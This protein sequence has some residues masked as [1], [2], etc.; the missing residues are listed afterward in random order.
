MLWWESYQREATGARNSMA[1][2]SWQ[3]PLCVQINRFTKFRS[4]DAHPNPRIT[5][6]RDE[7]FGRIEGERDRMKQA[8][9]H[10]RRVS[11]SMVKSLLRL[12][13]WTEVALRCLAR[14]RLVYSAGETGDGTRQDGRFLRGEIEKRKLFSV[15]WEQADSATGQV[16]DR[17]LA[18]GNDSRTFQYCGDAIGLTSALHGDREGLSTSFGPSF[19]R[20]PSTMNFRRT[21]AAMG[22][23]GFFTISWIRLQVP[24]RL[25]P[26]CLRRSL[27]F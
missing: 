25:V 20:R 2:R 12:P 10:R 16:K 3:S 8:V 4:F 13:C 6:F 9:E 15:F 23:N 21:H 11:R 5:P 27:P 14:R 1:N 26:K 18:A 24:G 7:W 19:S 22:K 17:A